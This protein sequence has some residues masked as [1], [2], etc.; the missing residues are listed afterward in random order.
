MLI[1]FPRGLMGTVP[2]THGHY[3]HHFTSM[4]VNPVILLVTRPSECRLRE[5]SGK[6]IGKV[7]STNPDDSHDS[8]TH[9]W[10]DDETL[11]SGHGTAV[12]NQCPGAFRSGQ[13]DRHWRAA[14]RTRAELYWQSYAG[15]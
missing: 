12:Y 7:G 6:A 10:G 5:N 8:P 14:C 3:A 15:S 13:G 11:V 4:L 1:N 2:V 9:S